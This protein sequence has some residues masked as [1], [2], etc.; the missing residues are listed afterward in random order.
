MWIIFGTK[1]QLTR[2][3]G[4]LRVQRR[5]GQCGEVAT[6]Y[7]KHATRTFRLYFIDIFD[8]ER[9]RVMACGCC[10]AYYATDELGAPSFG[11]NHE[12]NLLNDRVERAVDRV[13]DYMER[14][15]S[16]VGDGVSSLFSDGT[17]RPALP[18]RE[19]ARSRHGADFDIDTEVGRVDDE[20]EARFR[21]LEEKARRD[22]DR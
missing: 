6:F 1:A 11:G 12:R 4:G 9:H 13:G 14:A 21:E 3:P 7:E 18:P 8:Y 5:C 10:G 22:R 16:A 19:E 17:R 15:A 20:M 2:V